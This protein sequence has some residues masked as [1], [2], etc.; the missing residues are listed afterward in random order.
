MPKLDASEPY[1]WA[2][3]LAEAT[4]E[5]VGSGLWN[6]PPDARPAVLSE[7]RKRNILQGDPEPTGDPEFS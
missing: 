7:R 5:T 2:R 4:D 3:A 6:F 1:N